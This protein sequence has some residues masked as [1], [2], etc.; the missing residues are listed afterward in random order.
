MKEM[1]KAEFG[2]C[3][4]ITHAMWYNDTHSQH[5]NGKDSTAVFAFVGHV[6]DMGCKIATIKPDSLMY[7][8]G[9]SIERATDWDDQVKVKLQH[10]LTHSAPLDESGDWDEQANWINRGIFLCVM[11]D[12]YG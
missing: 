1:E 5:R 8:L 10:D 7:L 6:S 11:D 9:V 2:G 4:P 3:F 12:N